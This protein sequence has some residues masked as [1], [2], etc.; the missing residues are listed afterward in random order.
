MTLDI[1]DSSESLTCCN[2]CLP[3]TCENNLLRA[4]GQ[5]VAE[6][7]PQSGSGVYNPNYSVYCFFIILLHFLG[8]C[9]EVDDQTQYINNSY[10]LL[11]TRVP[12]SFGFIIL[13]ESYYF[14][15]LTHVNTETQRH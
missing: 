11:S 7:D 2:Q 3:R 6:Q 15:H 14:Q 1:H 13:Q 12:H 9:Y 10:H 5:E 8:T 4:H